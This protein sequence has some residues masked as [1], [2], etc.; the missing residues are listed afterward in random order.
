MNESDVKDAEADGDSAL[1]E[2]DDSEKRAD[3]KG[4]FGRKKSNSSVDEKIPDEKGISEAKEER[5]QGGGQILFAGEDL[6]KLNLSWVRSQIAVVQQ[7]PQ[8]FSASIF[9]NVAAGL[10]GTE[11]E[12]K[13]DIDGTKENEAPSPEDLTFSL[14]PEDQEK[15]NQ[16]TLEAIEKRYSPRSQEIRKKCKEALIKAQAWDFV[17]KL[18]EGMDTIVSGGRTGLL[19][20]G[21]RQRIAIARAIIREPAVLCLDEGTSALDSNTESKIKKMLQEEQESRGM[22]TILIA[23]R[24]STI[25]HADLIL[26]I[27]SGQ[28]VDRGTHDELL[29]S[30]S[31]STYRKMVNQQ[32]AIADPDQ[33]ESDASSPSTIPT[34]LDEKVDRFDGQQQEP[35]RT[36]GPQEINL[37]SDGNTTKVGGL[38]V[39]GSSEVGELELTSRNRPRPIPLARRTSRASDHRQWQVSG[40]AATLGQLEHTAEASGAAVDGDN[41]SNHSSVSAA[42]T[43]PGTVS[44]SIAGV[45]LLKKFKGYLGAQ[46]WWFI[47]GAL[48]ALAA[49]ASFPVAGYLTGEVVSSLSIQGDDSRLRSEANSWSSY[50]LAIACIDLVIVAFQST[51]LE[52]GSEHVARRLKT[53]GLAALLRQEIGYFDSEDRQA[54]GLTAAGEWD[55]MT[56]SMGR[57]NVWLTLLFLSSLVSLYSPSK[58]FGCYWTGH[59]SSHHLSR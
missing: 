29:A 32:K 39:G 15:E 38:T 7:Q 47:F 13:P 10:T 23:H 11:W 14:N 17:S 4:F 21:Q 5:I 49:G 58:C 19:S 24:L 36:T 55:V 45:T 6:R 34:K 42:P 40:R 41:R 3:K 25:S 16:K 48:G 33:E 18:P 59:R 28:V 57:L 30:K 54:G 8:L 37:E 53:E 2:S 46:K 27:K 1:E 26:V 44:V 9:E 56:G 20:G 43:A 52:V 50:F 35:E 51:F 31:D 22:T 12:Y